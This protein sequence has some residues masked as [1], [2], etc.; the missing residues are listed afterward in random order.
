VEQ[1]A[2]APP[3]PGEALVRV[4]A[5]GVGNWDALVRSGRSG[6]DLSLPL[7]LGAEVAGA[8]EAVAAAPADG[9][10][11]EPGEA[12]YGSTNSLFTAG[13]AELALCRVDM[14]T[15][16]PPGLTAVDA[17]SLPVAAAMAW[18]MIVEHARVMSGQ[19]VVVQGAAGNVG[20]LAVQI[21]RSRGADVVGTVRSAADEATVRELGATDVIRSQA[22]FSRLTRRA[23]VVVDTVGGPSQSLLFPL[24]VP[25]GLLVSS[26][27]RPDAALAARVDARVDYFI[28]RVTAAALEEIT[29]LVQSGRLRTRIGA[30]MPLS[31]VRIAHEML[32]GLLPRPQGKIVL[33][34]Q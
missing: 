9:L 22:D 1:V 6:L 18:Q 17:A 5:A 23:D 19:T 30:T 33:S 10:N 24:L 11:L 27:S 32:D 7:T 8:I 12:V 15:R 25:G 34:L 28:T 16:R 20:A 29:K 14:L 26:V 31:E 3:G 4:G 21:A 13:Y 2:S